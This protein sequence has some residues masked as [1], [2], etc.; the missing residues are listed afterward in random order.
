MA[1]SA[2]V[3]AGIVPNG[4]N[5]IPLVTEVS[6]RPDE[7]GTLVVT[8]HTD[9]PSNSTVLYGFTETLEMGFVGKNIPTTDHSVTLRDIPGL[10]LVYYQIVSTRMNESGELM[11]QLRGSSLKQSYFTPDWNVHARW[12]VSDVMSVILA[13]VVL[14]ALGRIIKKR[15]GVI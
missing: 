9:V 4:H 6:A 11:W 15:A 2:N 10:D 14:F 8:W 3:S 7:V 5:E 1:N 13:V 12:G